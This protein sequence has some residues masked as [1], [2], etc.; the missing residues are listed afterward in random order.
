MMSYPYSTISG[1]LTNFNS[2]IRG[3]TPTGLQYKL[4]NRKLDISTN[5]N[6]KKYKNI[7]NKEIEI[8]CKN[9]DINDENDLLQLLL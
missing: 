8:A 1:I 5:T 7:K 6:Y 4:Y 2:F 9:L 3:V